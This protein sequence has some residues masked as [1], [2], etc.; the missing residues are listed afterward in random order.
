MIRVL[1]RFDVNPG[2][3]DAFIEAW[4]RTTLLIREHRPG[5]RGSVLLRSREDPLKFSG[6]ATWDSSEAWQAA[7]HA[8]PLED[9]ATRARVA[10]L[11]VVS[12][13]EHFEVVS[14]L[15]T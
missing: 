14:D 3:E 6:F 7:R 12:H 8:P 15:T 4:K 11:R 13:T 5:A 1:Y 9:E 2:C 10:S